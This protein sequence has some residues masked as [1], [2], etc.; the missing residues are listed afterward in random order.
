VIKTLFNWDTELSR[1]K[2][3][4]E[5]RSFTKTLWPEAGFCGAATALLIR[6]MAA[7]TL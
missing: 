5:I 4:L 3:F 7:L 6:Y 2:T 1:E